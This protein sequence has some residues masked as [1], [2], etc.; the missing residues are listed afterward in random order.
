LWFAN[1]FFTQGVDDAMLRSSPLIIVDDGAQALTFSPTSPERNAA[2]IFICGA[3]V[4]AQAYAPLLRPIAEEGYSVFVIKLPYRFAP[5]EPQKQTALAHVRA[6][7]SQHPEVLNWVVSGHSLGGALACRAVKA[8]PEAI[9]ALVLIG[10]THP[11][12]DDLSNLPMPVTKVYAANDGVA[13][14]NKV[15]ANK[16]LLPAHTM[17]VEIKGGNHSQFGHYGDQFLDGTATISRETQQA[18]PRPALTAALNETR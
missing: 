17:W 9:S 16:K 6:V 1:S 7:I 5:L 10:T 2:L 11:K 4:T 13:P 12:E 3:G 18:M 8:N 15:H 14:S